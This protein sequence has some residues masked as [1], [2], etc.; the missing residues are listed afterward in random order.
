MTA[1]LGVDV[2]VTGG[3]AVIGGGAVHVVQVPTVSYLKGGKSYA[4]DYDVPGMVTIVKDMQARHAPLHA[5]IEKTSARPQQGV[6]STC[7]FCRGFGI[8]LGILATLEIPVTIVP[9]AVWKRDLGIAR[10]SGKGG[11]VLRAKQLFPAAASI[12]PSQHGLAE[13]LLIAEWARRQ[14][15]IRWPVEASVAES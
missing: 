3:I 2:G 12:R 14:H 7:S 8:W 5:A 1:F 15:G 9:P 10:G 13:A 4:R 6:V 11:S